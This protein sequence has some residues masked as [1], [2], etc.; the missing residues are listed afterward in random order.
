MAKRESWMGS[1]VLLRLATQLFERFVLESLQKQC[2]GP[3][4]RVTWILGERCNDADKLKLCEVWGFSDTKEREVKEM[5]MT[6]LW[7]VLR[8]DISVSS[9]ACCWKIFKMQATTAI[10]H[11]Y[12]WCAYNICTYISYIYIYI[13][14]YI[15]YLHLHRS[16]NLPIPRSIYGSSI[17]LQSNCTANRGTCLCKL[18][19]K[20]QRVDWGSKTR[21]CQI[22]ACNVHKRMTIDKRQQ[23]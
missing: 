16:I 7:P 15:F 22:H 20:Q 8:L 19:A 11:L 12:I 3:L 14:T 6:E 21:D 9:I 18:S 13:F 4:F 10:Y 1:G 5:K 23:S 17:D 2:F